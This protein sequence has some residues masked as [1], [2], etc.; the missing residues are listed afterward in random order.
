LNKFLFIQ[1]SFIGD[2]I[3][4]TALLEKMHA[5]QSNA[6]IDICVRK[7]NE[8]LFEGHPFINKVHVWNKK[9][10]KYKNLWA[11]SKEIKNENYDAVIN[12]QRFTSSGFLTV[13][14]GAK[15]KIG[16]RKNPLSMFFS[17][18]I[19]HEISASGKLHEVERNQKLIESFCGLEF[20][21]PKLYPSKKDFLKAN[22]ISNGKDYVT[23]SPASVWFT[24]QLPVKKWIELANSIPNSKQIFILGGPS[25]RTF[26][27]ELIEQCDR[28]DIQNLAGEL[29]LL[30]SAA[31]MRDAQMNYVNDSAPL[32]L[33]SAMNAPVTAFFC[34][35]VPAFGFTP[36]S[37]KSIILE[38]NEKLSCRPCGLHGF[39][40]CPKEHFKCGDI[41]IP[42]F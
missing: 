29:S 9:E 8:T 39:Q 34:S 20:A 5:R 37:E 3:L 30:G 23:L 42:S 13:R 6:Q 14:S 17:R 35:T 16:F 28:T 25:D 12:L 10:N 40:K 19:D 38:S 24:K 41:D 36:L 11:L 31:L 21:K 33:C 1:T 2:V 22:K 4:A 18:S 27:K 26:C 32:H 15:Q 7:G